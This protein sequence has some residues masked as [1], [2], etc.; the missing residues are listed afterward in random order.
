MVMHTI[1]ALGTSRMPDTSASYMSRSRHTWSSSAI[2]KL[3]CQDC[4]AASEYGNTWTVAPVSRLCISFLKG[5]HNARRS[6]SRAIMALSVRRI[7]A[8]WSLE[9]AIT[10]YWPLYTGSM[11]ATV[12]M[13]AQV[14]SVFPKL[15][16]SPSSAR[17]YRRTKRPSFILPVASIGSQMLSYCQFSRKKGSPW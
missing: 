5:S 2:T 16:G 1:S 8:A 14:I 3:K 4:T 11:F 13:S 15:R 10:A 17:L 6:G 9:D 12:S 7:L